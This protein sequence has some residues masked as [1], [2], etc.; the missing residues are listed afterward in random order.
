MRQVVL[1]QDGMS[2]EE[3]VAVAREGARVSL[4]DESWNRLERA[5]ALIDRWVQ[6]ERVIYGVTTGFGA[7][8]DVIISKEEART[9]Q[10]NILMSHSAGVGP[11]LPDDEVRAL[12]AL[13]LKD[14]A[15]GHSGIRPETTRRLLEV[16]NAGILPVVP[17]KGSV[18]ASGDLAPLAH[19]SLVL[20]GMGEARYQGE[21]MSGAEALARAGLEPLELEACEGLALANGTQLMT[22]IG[23]LALH[24]ALSLSKAADIAASMSLEVLMGSRTEFDA[25]I[26]QVR[27]HP[28]QA[29]AAEN[30]RRI[31]HNSDIISSHKD[32]SRVQDAYTLRC[33][34]QVHGATKDALNY[35]RTVVE[36][37]MNS[38]TNNP[39]IFAE[40]E[41]FLLGGNFHGQPVALAMDFMGMAVAE[42]ANISERRVE[43]LVNPQL[44]GLPAFL[45]DQGG[46]HSGFMIAQ[47]TAAALVSE[48][49]AL[50]HPACVDSIPT[51]ANKEDHVSMGTISARK[52]REIV[53]NTEH[54]IAIELLCAAQ[55]LDL[56]TNMKPGEGTCAAYQ[57]IRKVIP[58]LDRDRV[59]S[60]DIEAMTGLIRDGS[61]IRAVEDAVGPLHP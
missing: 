17:E 2:L 7:L 52:A 41:Q 44:S 26:H 56:F 25:R 47:Y 28:G 6:E 4:D 34:P 8:S 54:V 33:S 10:R 55:A 36:T 27:P 14:L 38:S 22:A 20:I 48:N 31:T 5:R 19:M 50:A 37:E 57:C 60:R 42:L 40:D 12:M 3:L 49:K 18:G 23:A 13:R 16:L 30:M 43:R 46:L 15:R 29:K 58:H 61:L 1:G 21:R 45:V 35:C 59:L 32:C 39:L 24:D 9:L 11:E 51:S 53:R